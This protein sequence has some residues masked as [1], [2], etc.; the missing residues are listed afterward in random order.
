MIKKYFI[1]VNIELKNP[2]TNEV[3]NYSNVD[4]FLTKNGTRYNFHPSKAEAICF[5]SY[6]EAEEFRTNFDFESLPCF[7]FFTDRGYEVRVYSDITYSFYGYC[8]NHMYSDVQPYEIVR[9]ISPKTIVIRQMDTVQTVKPKQFVSGG[10][11]AHCVDQDKQDYNYSS[12]KSNKLIQARLQKSGHYKSIVG[13][14]FLSEQPFKFH[15]YNF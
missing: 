13:K 8:N 11:S 9:V 10:F 5:Y 14:H 15:D 4:N 1:T 7:K 3:A 12:N 6:N 2:E